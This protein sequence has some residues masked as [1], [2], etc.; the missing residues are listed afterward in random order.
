[1]SV[2]V[3]PHGQ[4][5]YYSLLSSFLNY[6]YHV[7]VFREFSVDAFGIYSLESLVNRVIRL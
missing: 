5:F 2:D 4:G 6:N 1:M 3:N 7:G